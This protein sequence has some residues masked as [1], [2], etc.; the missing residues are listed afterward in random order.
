[1]APLTRLTLQLAGPMRILAASGEPLSL[2]NRKTRALLAYLAL[3]AGAH[4]RQSLSALF[5]QRS[6]DPGRTLRWHLS[7]IRHHLG[8]A[9]ILAATTKVQLNQQMVSVDMHTFVKRLH[10]GELNQ[11]RSAE[12]VAILGT[13]RGEFLAGLVLPDAPEFELWLLGQR[14]HLQ[15]L[16]E[17]GLD[18]LV[19]RLIQEQAYE[20]AVTWAQRL[21]ETNPLLE[22]GHMNLIWLYARRG[23]RQAALDQYAYCRSLLRRE[24]AVEPMPELVRLVESIRAERPLPSHVHP[25]QTPPSSQLPGQLRPDAQPEDLFDL[26]WQWAPL[27]AARSQRVYAHADALALYEAAL[28]AFNRLPEAPL[29]N[30]ETAVSLAAVH[31]QV[32]NLLACVQ[33][34]LMVG[35]PPAT[36]EAWLGAA[37]TLLS[38]HPHQRLEA[39]LLLSQAS[40]MVMQGRYETA[41]TTALA[42]YELFRHLHEPRLTAS[43]LALAGE[44]RLR[45]SKNWAAQSFFSEALTLFQAAGDMEGES[46][47]RS[48]LAH[49]RVNLGQVEAALV[50]LDEALKIA[51]QQQDPLAEAQV[52]LSLAHAWSYYY[53]SERISYFAT[54]ASQL[55]RQAQYETMVL[56]AE[57]YEGLAC[58]FAGDTT[59]G[60]AIYARLLAAAQQDGDR[61]LEGWMAQ[62]LGRIALELLDLAA[63]ERWFELSRQCRQESGEAQNLASDLLWLGRLRLGQNRPEEALALMDTAVTQLE[64]GAAD[65]YVYEAW[66]LY[67]GQ[68]EALT[69]LG[70]TD[71]AALR[72]QRAYEVL[73]AFAAQITDDGRRRAFLA[74]RRLERLLAAQAKTHGQD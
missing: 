13:Y 72:V 12:L 20:T 73:L 46:R 48:G 52:C 65:Y 21:V 30:Q 50:L 38:Q 61:W 14:A 49:A 10:G 70:Q 2:P 37:R 19:Q 55:F 1:M 24:L 35:R 57:C 25:Y 63:A 9:V 11:L 17:R 68:A 56:R 5:C 47:C 60:R 34:G 8:A 40:L 3:T 45:L 42:G 4:D 23:Q 69:A 59:G 32:E 62:A 36:L 7:A 29:V 67:L 54:R 18:H 39:L 53:D 15:R 44:A 27:A 43:C 64:T 66:D 22:E 33:L 28:V 6:A 26:I 51:R 41:V 16:Y 58:R 74:C 31:R 71:L